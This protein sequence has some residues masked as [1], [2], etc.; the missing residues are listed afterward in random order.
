[1]KYSSLEQFIKPANHESGIARRFT[2]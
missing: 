2:L 1:V